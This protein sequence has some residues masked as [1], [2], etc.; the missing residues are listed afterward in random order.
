MQ[1]PRDMNDYNPEFETYLNFVR[2]VFHGLLFGDL[3]FGHLFRSDQRSDGAAQT[4]REIDP[5]PKMYYDREEM[6]RHSKFTFKLRTRRKHC[7]HL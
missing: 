2:N 7:H 3:T 5:L 4:A 6:S 1:I